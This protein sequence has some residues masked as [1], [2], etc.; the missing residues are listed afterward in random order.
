MALID[1]WIHRYGAI[2]GYRGGMM[3]MRRWQIR[4]MMILV[5]EGTWG[6]HSLLVW[7]AYASQKYRYRTK[8]KRVASNRVITA[9]DLCQT[10][11][12]WGVLDPPTREQVGELL[13]V[14]RRDLA[15]IKTRAREVLGR[16]GGL[17][18]ITKSA[19]PIHGIRI[20]LADPDGRKPKLSEIL[21]CLQMCLSRSKLQ[22]KIWLD[23]IAKDYDLTI[24]E[25]RTALSR[26]IASDIIRQHPTNSH[27]HPHMVKCYWSCSSFLF[28]TFQSDYHRYTQILIDGTWMPIRDYYRSIMPNLRRSK[29]TPITHS[30]PV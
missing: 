22:R 29:P 30:V 6:W 12:A 16:P 3:I 18:K 13:P 8:N 10:L 20:L 24:P 26:L 27:R 19:I 1:G 4:G 11:G 21:I 14:V 5:S 28:R 25:L 9:G 23:T 2:T 17:F 15:M 7:V